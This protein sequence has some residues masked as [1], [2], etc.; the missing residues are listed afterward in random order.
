[1]Q[2]SADSRWAKSVFFFANQKTL[3]RK[4]KKKLY[5]WLLFCWPPF[6]SETSAVLFFEKGRGV[7]R[8]ELNMATPQG[9]LQIQVM[10]AMMSSTLKG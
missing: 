1:M 4:G 5:F 9:P 7:A 10:V 6:Y 2:V 8:N 3:A